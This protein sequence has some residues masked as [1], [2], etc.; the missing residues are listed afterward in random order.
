M[1]YVDYTFLQEETEMFLGENRRNKRNPKNIQAEIGSEDNYEDEWYYNRERQALKWLCQC[2]NNH[3]FD[4]RD[5]VRYPVEDKK[6]A[7]CQGKCP[8]CGDGRISM[9]SKMLYPIRFNYLGGS[10]F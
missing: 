5:R 7:P 4:Y 2:K 10:Q 6:H 9:W 8:V 3:H 1:D